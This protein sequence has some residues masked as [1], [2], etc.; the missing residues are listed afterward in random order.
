MNFKT[1]YILFGLLV[2]VLGVFAATQLLGVKKGGEKEAYVL[3]TMHQDPKNPVAEKDIDNVEI[4]WNSPQEETFQ[5]FRR[6]QK[7]VMEN[8]YPVRLEANQVNNLIR[9][10]INAKKD[11]AN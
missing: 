3:P 7:W 6:G 4:K 1:T 8:P 2:V 11:K 10:V 9:E 5:L